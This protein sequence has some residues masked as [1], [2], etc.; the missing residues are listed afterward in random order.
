MVVNNNFYIML[1]KEWFYNGEE[2][3]LLQKY[4]TTALMI[5]IVLLR[6]LTIRNTFNFSIDSLCSTLL[7]NKNNNSNMVK[8]IKSTIKK[9]N[10]DLFII[11]LDSNCNVQ[12][13]LSKIDNGTTYYC[14]RIKEVLKEKFIM[15]YDNEIDKMITYSK[16]K[17]NSLSDLITHFSFVCNGF[18]NSE[19]EEGYLCYFGSLDYIEQK[20]G[21]LKSTLLSNNKIFI[22]QNLLLLGNA[23]GSIEDNKYKNT[24]NIYARV[25]NKVEF[26]KFIEIKKASLNN[27]FESKTGKEQQNKQRRL[28]QLINQWKKNNNIE[29]YMDKD[30][31]TTKQF[32]ELYNLEMNYFNFVI[33]RGKELKNPNF[34]TI[35]RDGTIKEQYTSE[36]QQIDEE[37]TKEPDIFN[38]D[39]DIW[40]EDVEISLK[41]EMVKDYNKILDKRIE[42]IK[43]GR[44][45]TTQEIADEIFG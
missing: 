14:I 27:K 38:V 45:L 30:D 41:D 7:I 24:S 6:N 36:Q 26:D 44:H 28:K 12:A 2:E 43:M 17:K 5:Y 4:G 42:K 23:G 20:T 32:E 39:D 11:C 25:E 9:L 21:I 13:D 10:G 34:L 1:E 40:G 22:E 8:K 33:S 18:N 15:V 3:T 19:K 16:G 37:Y 29:E 31:L 35:K